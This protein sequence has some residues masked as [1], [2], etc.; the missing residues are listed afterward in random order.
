MEMDGENWRL[1]S[2]ALVPGVSV[3]L[4]GEN[5]RLLQL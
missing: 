3:E 5:W 4:D 1:C 2:A